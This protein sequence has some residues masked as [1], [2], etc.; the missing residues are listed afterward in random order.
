MPNIWRMQLHPN[1]SSRSMEH[2]TRCLAAGYVGL[3]FDND[4]GDLAA[5]PASD[6]DT[7]TNNIHAFVHEIQ[8]EDRI[9]IFSRNRPLAMVSDIGPYN[10]IREPVP[11]LRIW[12]RHF[13]QFSKLSWYAD[14]IGNTP[15]E[16]QIVMTNTF[17][18]ASPDSETGKLAMRWPFP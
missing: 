3:G 6:L 7:K 4:P 2:T 16:P 5:L 15:P 17:S 10:F 9:V 8:R 18:G 1:E 12:F 14:A 11:E 13:R